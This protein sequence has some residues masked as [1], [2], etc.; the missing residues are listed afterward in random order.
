VPQLHH[1]PQRLFKFSADR[2]EPL[3]QLFSVHLAGLPAVP[4]L[5]QQLPQIQSSLTH[6][7]AGAR[8]LG[9][10]GEIT[11]DARPTELPLLKRKLVGSRKAITH[12]NAAKGGSQQL[13]RGGAR[14]AQTLRKH[15]QLRLHQ[16]PQP[17]TTTIGVAPVGSRRQ[18]ASRERI[19]T[20]APPLID[21]PSNLPSR[22][23]RELRR[24][25]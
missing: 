10:G 5:K 8:A 23:T 24:R 6:L 7:G 15:G 16:H 3:P 18:A 2:A 21:T 4:V 20:I 1:L 13:H 19:A 12:H 17:A 25:P 11:D 9:N 22:P 14:T